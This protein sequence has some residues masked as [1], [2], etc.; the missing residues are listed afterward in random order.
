MKN[1]TLTLPAF[2]TKIKTAPE[3]VAFAETMAIVEAN[4]S[5]SET[6]FTNGDTTN[7]A[8]ENN[9]SCK[10]FALAQDLELTP[11]ETLFCF[12]E[13][14]RK[15]VLENPQGTDH[16]NIRNFQTHAWEGISFTASPLQRK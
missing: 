13:F 14:Y 6:A 4:Y 16:Q 12:G 15:D 3:T 10:V 8:G 9:G 11:T 5:F 2:I 1:D 7:A